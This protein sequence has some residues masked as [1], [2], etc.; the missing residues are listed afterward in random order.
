MSRETSIQTKK[1]PAST[2][3]TRSTNTLHINLRKS[4]QNFFV[5]LAFL[6]STNAFSFNFKDIL[7]SDQC[8]FFQF[9][10]YFII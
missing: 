10:G 4:L 9:Q 3:V 6:I 8:I 2:E 7:L 1:T 5:L